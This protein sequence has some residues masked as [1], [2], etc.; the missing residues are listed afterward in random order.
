MGNRELTFTKSEL[1][2]AC[3][4]GADKERME[5]I[6][7]GLVKDRKETQ[8]QTAKTHRDRVKRALAF[9]DEHAKTLVK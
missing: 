4:A 8:K 7:T 1:V 9:Y 2:A 3:I 6:I 5:S